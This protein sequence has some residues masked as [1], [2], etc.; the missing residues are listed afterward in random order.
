MRQLLTLSRLPSM[1]LVFMTR[2]DAQETLSSTPMF[3]S[4]FNISRC[5]L[6][7]NG[8]YTPYK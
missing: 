8:T 3:F 6:L 4:H 7:I 2:A 1:V 5:R